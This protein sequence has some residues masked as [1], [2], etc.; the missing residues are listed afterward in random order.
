[1]STMNEIRW[2]GVFCFALIAGLVPAQTEQKRLRY[3]APTAKELADAMDRLRQGRPFLVDIAQLAQAGVVATIPELGKQFAA[4]QDQITK[5][6]VARALL[7]LG[8]K[9]ATYWDCLA[10][11]AIV[12]VD[13]DEPFPSGFDTNGKAVPGIW[14]QF[15][16]WA[17]A[18]NLTTEAA[19]D[20]ATHDLP[21]KVR[22]LGVTGDRRAIPLLRSGPVVSQLHDSGIRGR[23]AHRLAGQ[24]LDTVQHRGLPDCP[25]GTGPRTGKVLN[26]VRRPA[27]A[28]HSQRVCGRVA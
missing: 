19:V 13:S 25:R 27:S 26:G 6:A 12:A 18:H 22:F 28:K 16:A 1:M 17:K 3:P 10:R 23:G 4:S 14:P 20:L 5:E 24:G 8:D 15:A 9:D 11:E 2:T 7:K 21:S